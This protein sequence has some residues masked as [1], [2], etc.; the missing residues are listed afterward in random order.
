MPVGSHATVNLPLLDLIHARQLI[1]VG[2]RG[3]GTSGF[4][5]RMPL[6]EEGRF[7]PSVLAMQR[8]P[9]G[10]AETAL[11]AM[12]SGAHPPG[13]NVIDRCDG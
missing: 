5:P 1:V 3:L 10:Q 2:T 4:A 7:D 6:I 11:R 12:D 8:I 13:I 9:L